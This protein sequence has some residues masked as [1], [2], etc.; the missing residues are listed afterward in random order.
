MQQMHQTDVSYSAMAVLYR[1]NAQSRVLEEMLVRAGIPYRI[2]GGMRFYDRK[3]VR[4]IV[5]YLRVIVNPAD[6]VSLRRIINQPKRSI[7]DATIAELV[8]SAAEQD[9]SLFTAMLEPPQTLASRARKCV[10]EFAQLMTRL[11]IERET[12]P[13]AEF[14]QRLI[15]E[16]GLLAQYAKE[17]SDEA[18]TRVENIQEFIGAVQEF[19]EKAETP[20][21]EDFLENVA[22]V[23]D[24]D[25][26]TE[27]AQAVT[28]MTLHSA[29]GLE[30]KNVFLIGMEDGIFPSLRSMNDE[31]RMEEERRLCYVGITRA[32]DRLFLSYATQRM[33]FNL[34]QHNRPSQFLDEIPSR[35]IDGGMEARQAVQSAFRAHDERQPVSYTHLDVYKRQGLCQARADRRLRPPK[36]KRQGAAGVHVQQEQLERHAH[37][38][39]ALRARAL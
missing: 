38:G 32:Q 23:T 37:R 30:F 22:L 9:Y 13:L 5:A 26:M 35:L 33:L 1:M 39:R 6:D 16:T 36:Q 15:D 14:V 8:R 28:L 31:E 10:G 2:Y 27:D 3:E 34:M 24:L 11:T 21:L 12:M 20:T 18:R 7:G 29:K 4:D 19:A 17:D 25:S